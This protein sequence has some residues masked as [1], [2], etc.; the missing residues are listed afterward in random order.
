MVLEVSLR[1]LNYGHDYTMWVSP[2][3]GKLM[4]KGHNVSKWVKPVKQVLILNPG[5]AYKYFHSTPDI[6]TPD[7]DVF[8]KVKRPNVFRIFVL[9]G[10]AAAGFP[11]LPNGSFSRYLQQRLSLEYPHSKIEVVNCALSAV[12]SYTLRDFMP[13]ILK[14]KPDLIII[15]AGNN[16]YVGALG[17]GSVESFGTSRDLVNLVVYLEQFRTFQLLRNV[18]K[19]LTGLFEK[20]HLPTGTLMS[21]MARKQYIPFD[22]RAYREGIAQFDGNMT[23]LLKMAKQRNVPVILGTLACNLKDQYPFVSVNENGFPRADSVFMQARRA[24]ERGSYHIADSLFRYAKDLDALRFRPPSAINTV[25]LRLGREFDDPVVNIDSAFDAISP[26]H[27]VGNNLM[28]DHVHPTLRGYEIIGGLYYHEMEEAN[29]LPRTKPLGLSDRQQDSITVANFPFCGLDSVMGDYRVKA[30]KND[31][32]FVSE[33]SRMPINKLLRPKDYIDSLAYKVIVDKLGW[34]TA[35]KEASLRYYSRRD[36]GAFVRV[37]R[38]LVKQYPYTMVNYDFAITDLLKAKDYDGAYY[39]LTRR[40][41]LQASAFTEKWIGIIDLVKGRID[42][43]ESHLTASLKF[44]GQ[45]PQIWYYL[46]EAYL[47]RREY[48]RALNSIGSALKLQPNFPEALTLRAQVQEAMVR[49]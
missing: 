30:L 21:R 32:P 3:K 13:G 15:Y 1:I 44:N 5:I 46:T 43:A 2:V 39:F 38:V 10:S 45:D 27:I 24:L 25:I 14:E 35:H 6:P 11:F 4:L 36:L 26:N 31:W 7:G 22:S 9:G 16:E 41:Q 28:T 42:S 49:R 29:L 40:N 34:A 17:V 37:M 12:N 23:D 20:K 48:R 19:G 33:S 47:H 8:E 18:I